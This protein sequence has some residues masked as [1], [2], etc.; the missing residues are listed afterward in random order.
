MMPPGLGLARPLV[1]RLIMLNA[2]DEHAILL[3]QHA[4]D[5]AGLALVLAG[6]C[7]IT[8]S[9]FLILNFLA[10]TAPRARAR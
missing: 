8:L 3:A 5:L 2:L 6:R 1:W 4:Q 9:P 7:T 10:I